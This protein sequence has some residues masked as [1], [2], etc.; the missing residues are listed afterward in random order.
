MG[1][2]THLGSPAQP[3]CVRVL[4]RPQLREIVKEIRRADRVAPVVAIT[5]RS[6]QREPVLPAQRVREIV[7]PSARLC[8]IPT[9][10]LT[11]ALAV[12][13]GER[14]AVADGAARIWWARPSGRHADR[15]PL[16]QAPADG[17]GEAA[18]AELARALNATRPLTTEYLQ[19]VEYDREVALRRG[20]EL[21][22]A[23]AERQAE[24]D[25]TS[26]LLQAMR[27]R[28]AEAEARLR[29]R[30]GGSR[31]GA[32]RQARRPTRREP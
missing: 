10:H 15:H 25:E 8:F 5:S 22:T 26:A 6:G 1:G 30:R 17:D 4:T 14:L 24:L 3:A 20:T 19:A 28:L 29:T 31:A 23:L 27:V 32:A 21:A 13:L 11:R 12:Q 16:I 2:P 9:G 7:G 18:L